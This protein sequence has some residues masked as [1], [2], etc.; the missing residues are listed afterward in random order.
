MN[1]QL[2]S[3]YKTCPFKCPFCCAVVDRDYP[4]KDNLYKTNKAKYF[5]RLLGAIADNDIQTVVI[6]GDTEPTLFE[7]WLSECA[8]FIRAFFPSVKIELQT[9]NYNTKVFDIDRIRYSIANPEDFYRACCA[10]KYNCGKIGF[11]YLLSCKLTAKDITKCRSF[12]SEELGIQHTVKVL[13]YSPTGNLDIDTWIKNNTS[14]I[15]DSNRVSFKE[16]GIWL[17]ENCMD[18]EGRYIIF[19]I[20]GK[21]YKDWAELPA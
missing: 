13:Q 15:I 5:Q 6:T 4:W 18:T 11:T 17:D 3:P 10:N 20:D 2:V 12:I 21:V 14:E 1:L 16:L 7:D 8:G 9:K 19:R